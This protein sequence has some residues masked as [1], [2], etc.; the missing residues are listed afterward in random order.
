[1]R[2]G[3][4][5]TGRGLVNVATI[6]AALEQ[7]RRM[8]GRL[9]E[10][11]VKM[12]AMTAEQ[13]DSVMASIEFS[14]PRLP[15][16]LA[17]TGI[18]RAQLMN[19][20]LKFMFL[21]GHEA[22]S[23]LMQ[24]MRLPYSLVNELMG[25][26]SHRM[27]VQPLG[28]TSLGPFQVIRYTLSQGGRNAAADALRQNQYLGPAP[29]PLA[30]FQEQVGKQQIMDEFVTAER[31]RKGLGGL[32]VPDH[33]IRKLLPAINAGRTILLFGPPGNGK[34]VVASRVAALFE[35]VIYVP[36]AVEVAG[37]I[38]K[39]F[40]RTLHQPVVSEDLRDDIKHQELGAEA[41][42]DRW[43]ACRRPFAVAGGELTMEMLDLQY[44]AETKLYDAPLHVKALN[45][46]FL[47]DDFGRQRI[48]PK[49]LLDRWIV[50]MESRIDYLRLHTGKSFSLP[51]DELLIFST[52]IDPR[53]IMDPAL[54]R[55]ISYKV[56]LYAPNREEYRR[57]FDSEVKSHGLEL[58]DEVFDYVVE[59]LSVRGGFGLAYFQP[60]FVCDQAAQICRSFEMAPQLTKELA[61]E[62]LSNLYVQIEDQAGGGGAG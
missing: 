45:G 2:L 29:V 53:E 25:E 44:D 58:A 46:V 16:T 33:Y 3:E 10:I 47:I 34:T 40:D 42:D 35:Q 59:A 37:F 23:D 14:T 18:A 26:A 60:K 12:G 20:M 1:M 11:L 41:F 6:Y 31:L 62:A 49:A 4:I 55:R 19:L 15:R 24:M 22:L 21:E 38:M 13:L 28:A 36:H 39:V 5:L 57:L 56:K 61:M 8:G 52:N 30:A 54:L 9:G 7:Q 27:L 50:P 51:F 17:E 32:I 48:E 43:V